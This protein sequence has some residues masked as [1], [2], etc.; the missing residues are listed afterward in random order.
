MLIEASALVAILLA[1]LNA[2]AL[3]LKIYRSGDRF[4]HAVSFYEATLAIMRAKS[5]APAVA[6]GIVR[7]FLNEHEIAVQPL[8]NEHA[9][10]ALEAF[11]RFGKG[12]HRAALNMGDCFSYAAAMAADA[13]I[14]FVG[15]DFTHTDLPAA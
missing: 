10:L 2:D 4:T 8:T 3:A 13:P 12:R 6:A 1:E 7:D 15:E 11:A 14:L 5:L 9:T